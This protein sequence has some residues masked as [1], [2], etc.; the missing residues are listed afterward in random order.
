MDTVNV[1]KAAGREGAQQVQA[2][3]GLGIGLQ[4]ARRIGDPRLMGRFKTVDD[5]AAIAGVFHPTNHLGVG[6]TRLGELAGHPTD[7]N[8]RHLGAIGQHHGHLQHN[9]KGVAD[10]I[11]RKFGEAFGAIAALQQE[12]IA[13]S[14]LS[15]LLFQPPRLTGKDQGGVFGQL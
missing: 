9:A 5:V 8:H 4:H 7:F 14:G 3:R 10:V 11:G 1:S 13:L 12:R 6:R 2:G 15:Q